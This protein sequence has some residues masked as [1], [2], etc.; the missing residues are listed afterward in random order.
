MV[1]VDVDDDTGRELG[2][3]MQ[4]VRGGR[5]DVDPR[6][7]PAGEIAHR[8]GRLVGVGQPARE[9]DA[10][11][12]LETVRQQ[13]GDEEFVRLRRMPRQPQGNVS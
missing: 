7:Q 2:R 13:P 11:G 3:T 12:V 4:P 1:L 8:D 5:A 6:V 10:L 9:L